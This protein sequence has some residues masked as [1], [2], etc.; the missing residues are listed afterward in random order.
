MISQIKK[1]YIDWPG[2]PEIMDIPSAAKELVRQGYFH[3]LN[4]ATAALLS[5]M[6]VRTRFAYYKLA[7]SNEQLS[8]L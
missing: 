2:L 4:I 5:G 1:M 3:D 6:P 8:S 7:R